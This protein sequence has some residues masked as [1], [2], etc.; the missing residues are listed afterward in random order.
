M[1]DFFTLQRF[2]RPTWL[3]LAFS[4]V[5]VW[6]LS[7]RSLSGLGT[8]R[9]PL[10][11]AIRATVVGLLVL[12][13][14]GTNKILKHDDLNVL[15]LL[16][17]S[18]SVPLEVRRKAEQ[19]VATACRSVKPNDRAGVLTFDGLT[20][21][22]Q[23]PSKPGPSGALHI[24]LPLADGQ[25]PDRTNLA[26]ALRMA[27]A[28]AIDSANNRVVLLSDGNQNIGDAVEEARTAKANQIPIEVIPLR[29]ERGVEVVNEELRA[30]A[31]AN[32]HEQVTLTLILKSDRPTS[33]TIYVYQRIGSE[34]K[35]LDLDPNSKNFGVHKNLT[36]GRNAFTIR[37]P[38]KEAQGHEFRSEFIPDDKEADA[39]VQNNV[40][41]AFTNIEGPQTL[42]FIGTIQDREEDR[43]LVEALRGE[44][45]RVTWETVDTVSLDTSLLQGYAAVVL[46]NVPAE[47]FSAQQ[48]QALVT[49]VRDLGGGLI[50]LGG[51]AGFGAGGWQGSLVEDIMPIRFDVEAI[52]QIPRGALAIIMHSCEMPQGNKWG[53]DVAIAALQTLSRLDYYGITGYTMNGVDWEVKMQ[54]ATNKEAI[55]QQIRKMQNGDMPD[56]DSSMELAYQGLMSCKDAAQRHM[57]I[58]SDGDCSGPAD[59]LIKKLVSQSISCSTVAIFPH[60]SSSDPMSWIAKATKGRSYLLNKSGDERQLPKIF[61]KEART[62]RRPLIRDEPFKPVSRASLSDLL[63]GIDPDSLPELGG[64]VVTTPRRVVDVEMPLVTKRG[65]PLLAHWRCGFGRT[66][67][68]TSGRWKHWG[69]DW[70]SWTAFSKFW[71]QAIR[72]AMKQGSAADYDVTTTL[73]GNEGHVIIESV[74]DQQDRQP[75]VLAGRVV[76]PDGSSE[77]LPVTPTGPGRYEARFKIGSMG[78]YLV[79]LQS[80]D[81]QE[82]KPVVINTGLTLAYSPEFKDLT[83]NESLLRRLAE[84][85]DGRT[86]A[87]DSDGKTVFAHHQPPVVSRSPIWEM[88]LKIALFLFLIDVAVRRI[89][90]DPVKVW[91]ATRG[92]I[93]SLAGQFGVGRRAEATLSDLKMAREKVRAEKT[94]E[95]DGRILAGKGRGATQDEPLEIG[96]AAGTKFE[97]DPSRLKKRATGLTEALG[98]PVKPSEESTTPQSPAKPQESQEST[99][100]RLLKAKRRSRDQQ[101]GQGHDERSTV[102]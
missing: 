96:P 70:T 24:A 78:T 51:D 91:A 93:A 94:R 90:I 72:W 40:A 15:F 44:K 25:N 85:T 66:I 48:Q 61:V 89:A 47:Y 100:A 27:A 43:M 33:G 74:S 76:R 86:L 62:V 22:E 65:D 64:Y 12:T 10:S 41:R 35:R 56:F 11:V 28:C 2:D 88:L 26:Q 57:I 46:A 79:N 34:E 71:A 53:I 14:A 102:E 77:I 98:G 58:I 99:T 73:E 21:I 83:P 32:L 36:A 49:Y 5:L 17:L 29:Y 92:Y 20:N 42:L 63:S 80:S 23:L 75:P 97:A 101:E 45:I 54:L 69:S 50:M 16:D 7:R 37:L 9:G 31:Y 38:I 52:K 67:A 4:L 1:L 68:F 84:E 6:W 30:P 60:G 59:S 87:L 18:R 39:I 19:F 8:I 13:I 81:T 82:D 95:G 55:I 3:W